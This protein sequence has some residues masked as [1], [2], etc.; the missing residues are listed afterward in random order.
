MQQVTVFLRHRP[1]T[2][3]ISRQRSGSPRRR[4]RRDE[5]TLGCGVGGAVLQ[6]KIGEGREDGKGWSH[7]RTRRGSGDGRRSRWERTGRRY[8]GEDEANR[9]RP[10]L[11]SIRFLLARIALRRDAFT[12]EAKQTE[13]N[14]MS[15]HRNQMPLQIIQPNSTKDKISSMKKKGNCY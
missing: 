6:A 10:G 1:W 7:A 13:S 14:V 9:L 15:C 4:P 8:P 5:N 2:S 12:V 11:S 3:G